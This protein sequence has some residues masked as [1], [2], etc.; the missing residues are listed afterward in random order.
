[1]SSDARQARSAPS[2]AAA[3]FEPLLLTIAN[4]TILRKEAKDEQ[5]QDAAYPS[6]IG[7]SGIRR[8]QGDEEPPGPD[9]R[10]GLADDGVPPCPW[11]GR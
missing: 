11:P 4:D 6:N 2:Q 3:L 8:V 9:R 10:Q 1:M 5:S 7:Q